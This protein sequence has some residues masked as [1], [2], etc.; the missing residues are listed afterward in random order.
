MWF[1]ASRNSNNNFQVTQAHN[2]DK[3]GT[4]T[5]TFFNPLWGSSSSGANQVLTVQVQTTSMTNY[6]DIMYVTRFI[7]MDSIHT[8]TTL[9]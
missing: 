5:T 2:Y 6:I 1:R 7:S 9:L 3:V 4:N 8:F